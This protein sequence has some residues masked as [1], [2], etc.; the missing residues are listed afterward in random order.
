MELE[1][2]YDKIYRYCYF[3]LQHVQKAEDITQETFLRY[4]ESKRYQKPIQEH[5]RQFF[6]RL[7]APKPRLLHMVTTQIAF[8]PKWSWILSVIV[9]MGAFSLNCFFPEKVLG[10]VLGTIPFFVLIT[11]TECVRSISYGMEELEMAARFSLK[12]IVLARLGILGSS[13]LLLLLLLMPFLGQQI[14][15]SFLLAAQARFL[16]RCFSL[17]PVFYAI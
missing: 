8:L 7:E 14:L 13:N 16:L 6:R 15:W 1:E 5:K 10:V 12:S 4:L 17:L 11:V 2:Q 9:F 3:K